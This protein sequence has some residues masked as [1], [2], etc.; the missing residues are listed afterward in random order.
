MARRIEEKVEFHR[1]EHAGREC[2]QRPQPPLERLGGVGR[3]RERGSLRIW[4][5]ARITGGSGLRIRCSSG[6][7]RRM[8]EG[9]VTGEGVDCLD[10]AIS[11]V[12]QARYSCKE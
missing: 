8:R 3:V 7:K 12:A 9:P 10:T 11:Q 2:R 1:V 6:H 4:L 5:R